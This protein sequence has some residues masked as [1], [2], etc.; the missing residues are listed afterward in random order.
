MK[1]DSDS[2]SLEV[3]PEYGGRIH[4][5]RAF[6]HD[7]LRTPSAIEGHLPTDDYPLAHFYWGSYPLIPWVNRIPYGRLTFRGKTHEL[8]LNLEHYAIHGEAYMR[9]W[10]QVDDGRLVF[11]G[12][13]GLTPYPWRY[14]AEQLF[15]IDGETVTITI[16]LRND[17]GIEMPGGIGIHPWF[18]A[19]IPLLVAL[20]AS[21]AYPVDTC[22]P[23]GDPGPVEG[24]L[25][26]RL[27]SPVP[28]GTDDLWTGLTDDHI[29]LVWPT[30]GVSLSYGFSAAADHVVMAAFEEVAAVAI[31]PVTHAADGYRLL[32]QKKKGAIGVIQ[33]G[34]SLELRYT[35]AFSLAHHPTC[36]VPVPRSISHSTASPAPKSAKHL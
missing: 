29:V 23:N 6:G 9:A 8:P 27:I 2:I 28:W 5:L 21:L 10:I 3:L 20:P 32:D 22:I 31:E 1:V 18:R 35:F 33:P 7:V 12:G 25:D 14:S 36:A 19:D 24:R 17:S 11:S 15:E 13:G 30:L 16:T 34:S 4:R 26:R